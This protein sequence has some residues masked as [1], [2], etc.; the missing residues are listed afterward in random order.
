MT[1]HT[2]RG[3]LPELLPL[4]LAYSKIGLLGF[5]GG[6]AVLSFIRQELVERRAWLTQHEF[7]EVVEMAALAPGAVT[8]NVLSAIA[9]RRAGPAGLLAGLLA[10]LWPSF[11]LILLLAQLGTLAHNPWV[12]GAYR[13][14]EVAV[15]GLLADV[16]VRLWNELPPQRYLRILPLAAAAA[17]LFGVNPA[18]TV[19]LA[20]LSGYGLGHLPGWLASPR[21]AKTSPDPPAHSPPT[22]DVG[23]C[24]NRRGR[25]SEET[26]VDAV[27]GLRPSQPGEPPGQGQ[28]RSQGGEEDR[29]PHP[30]GSGIELLG[31]D[32]GVDRHRHRRLQDQGPGRGRS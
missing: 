15:V 32:Q 28:R 4:M 24:G 3:R 21:A 20:A 25:R 8:T 7:D 23:G 11:L 5:G 13:G 27:G 17:T 9:F 22:S 10:A 18:T 31:Q 6:Y 16:A 12:E 14:L 29:L 2:A 26:T 19:L 1:P 30:L